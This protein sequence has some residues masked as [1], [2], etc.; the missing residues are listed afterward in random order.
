MMDFFF[1]GFLSLK[2]II[3]HFV[4]M[5]TRAIRPCSTSFAIAGKQRSNAIA[6]IQIVANRVFPIASSPRGMPIALR[7]SVRN[8]VEIVEW[9]KKVMV[10]RIFRITCVANRQYVL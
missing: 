6:H 5:L 10:M 3:E 7:I 2:I 4:I 1:L 8:V 9:P